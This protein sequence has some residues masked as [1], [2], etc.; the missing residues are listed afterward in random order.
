MCS[1]C[2]RSTSGPSDES[3]SAVTNIGVAAH[4]SAAASGQGARRYDPNMT[5][6]ERRHI[7]NGIWL[8]ASCSVL[9]D[10]DEERFTIAELRRIRD[11]HEASRR[12]DGDNEIDRSNVIAIGH[13]II[14]AG[15]ILCTGPEGFKVR[16]LHFVQGSGRDLM[17]FVNEFQRTDVGDR[18]VLLNELGYGGLLA[19]TPK[20][21]RQGVDY[22]LEFKFLERTSRCNATQ[23]IVSMCAE[24]GRLIEGMD[25]LVQNF[26]RTL[27]MARGEWFADL[28]LGSHL[29][30]LYWRYHGSPWFEPLAMNEIV[31]LASIPKRNRLTGVDTT[32]FL[33]VNRVNRVSV[34]SFELVEQKLKIEVDFEVEG[35][36]DWSGALSVFISTPEQLAEGRERAAQHAENIRRIEAE[37]SQ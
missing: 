5:S 31:R 1:K 15:D 24:T 23:N 25:A 37:N 26:E 10:R 36:G 7:S 32:P 6:E 16:L 34:T 3:P 9:I 2:K 20:V 14:T 17:R 11:E 13:D 27:G 33:C 12:I 29:A 4:I 22:E 35:V 21:S 18:Y 30:D 28:E 19:E 8:C